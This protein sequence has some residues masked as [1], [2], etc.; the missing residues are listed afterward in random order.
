MSTSFRRLDGD[1][2]EFVA[3][4]RFL[5]SRFDGSYRKCGSTVDKWPNSQEL[6]LDAIH[7]ILFSSFSHRPT[8]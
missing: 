5:T 1:G 8:I 6:L 7:G 4:L 3:R 2:K